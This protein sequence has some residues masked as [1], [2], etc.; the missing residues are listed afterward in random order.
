MKFWTYLEIKTKIEKDLDLE[1]ETFIQPEELLGYVNEAIDEAEAE[2]HGLYED[3]FLARLAFPLVY[4]TDSYDLPDNI[5]GTKIR[6]LMYQNGGDTFEIKEMPNE[7]KIQLYHLSQADGTSGTRFYEYFLENTTPGSPQLVIV[8]IPLEAGD[9]CT[10]WYLRNANR[11]AEDTDICDIPEF[12]EFVIQYAKVRC[13]EKEGHPNLVMALNA[14]EQ[15]RSQMT[16]TLA[17]RT[18]N[19]NNEIEAEMFYYREQV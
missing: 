9:F 7:K 16:S 18:A 11:L 13:Y 10:L 4:G 19:A 15:Q 12:V 3:Y 14:L 2:I 1:D 17:Q 6:K 5:Y 8:P